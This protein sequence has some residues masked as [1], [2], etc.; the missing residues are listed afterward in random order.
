MIVADDLDEAPVAGT[1]AFGDH[2]AVVRLLLAAD[3]AETNANCHCCTLVQVVLHF[4]GLIASS[5]FPM[6]TRCNYRVEA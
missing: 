1:R 4:S 2:N 5:G 6:R 3:S